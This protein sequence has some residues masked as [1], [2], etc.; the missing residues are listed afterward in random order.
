[1]QEGTRRSGDS[2]LASFFIAAIC[3]ISISMIHGLYCRVFKAGMPFGVVFGQCFADT[4]TQGS[5]KKEAKIRVL[6]VH[7][8]PNSRFLI[9]FGNINRRR[10]TNN[11]IS[12]T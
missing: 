1:M 11:R 2:R 12:E 10:E 5:I 3:D 8:Q 7:Q 9:L 4:K 6:L